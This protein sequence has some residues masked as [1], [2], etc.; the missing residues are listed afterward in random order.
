[1]HAMQRCGGNKQCACL[2]IIIIMIIIII[3]ITIT[4]TTYSYGSKR[5]LVCRGQWLY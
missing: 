3:I 2:I 1:M 4:T 5:Y